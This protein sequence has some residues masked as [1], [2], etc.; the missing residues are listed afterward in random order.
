VEI[1]DEAGGVVAV[2]E[3]VIYCATRAAH[4]ERAKLRSDTG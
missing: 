3:R 4:E 2:V 1:K